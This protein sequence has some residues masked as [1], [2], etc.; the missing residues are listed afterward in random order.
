MVIG[1]QVMKILEKKAGAIVIVVL[2]VAFVAAGIA[3]Y[4]SA[5]PSGIDL[6][7]LQWWAGSTATVM[8]EIR[9]QPAAG[10]RT[11]L[12]WDFALIAGYVIGL[13]LACGLGLRVFWTRR[14]RAWAKL[15]LGAALVAGVGN[16]GQDVLLL[17]GLG[18]GLRGTAI[19]D[20]AE[21]L[22]FAKFS[23]L[24]IAAAV[25]IAGVA[26]TVGRLTMSKRTTE[27]WK[28]VA[29]KLKKASDHPLVI[30]PPLIEQAAD[31]R[32][33]A[34]ARRLSG[35]EWWK[36]LSTGSHTRWAQGFASPSDRP[37]DAVGIC[38]SGGGIRS[39]SVALGAL[40]G[41]R[42]KEVLDETTYLV[43]V[44]GGGYTVGATSWP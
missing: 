33:H 2:A 23:A 27:H 1:K 39:A 29:D 12:Y 5:Q 7:R 14:S 35:Q 40:Q 3:I 30:P 11:A 37:D 17:W 25:G 22:S 6:V 4:A 42:K 21:A 43:S 31:G 34:S 18:N 28:T 32:R 20:V 19:L 41:L 36:E 16:A 24:L 38:V 8:D 9:H 15:G 10:Y 26:V 13:V 44:S